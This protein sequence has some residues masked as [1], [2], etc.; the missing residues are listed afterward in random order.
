V[1]KG[2]HG[3]DAAHLRNMRGI[4]YAAG[5]GIREHAE[6]GPFENVDIYPFIAQ[7]LGLRV[8]KIDGSS[9]VLQSFLLTVAAPRNQACGSRL[10]SALH[11]GGEEVAPDLVSAAVVAIIRHQL[12]NPVEVD[13]RLVP[14]PQL[15]LAPHLFR[16]LFTQVA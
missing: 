11:K 2:V 6:V 16:Y 8:G 12:F 5:P 13:L 9:S 14:R 1:N 10:R 3:Y 7:L 15:G 4:F